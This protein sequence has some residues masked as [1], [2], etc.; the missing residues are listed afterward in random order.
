[1][2]TNN[3]NELPLTLVIAR[4]YIKEVVIAFLDYFRFYKKS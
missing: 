4:V 2:L 3:L 1:M